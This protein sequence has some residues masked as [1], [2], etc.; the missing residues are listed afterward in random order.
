MSLNRRFRNGFSFGANYTWGISFTGN[1]GLQK[2]LQHAADGTFSVRADQ[3]VYEALNRN[4]DR[5]PHSFKANAVWALPG[6]P[7][8]GSGSSASL[9]T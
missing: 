5:R 6:T 8:N 2:R 4:L 3:A 9:A 1:T 7:M